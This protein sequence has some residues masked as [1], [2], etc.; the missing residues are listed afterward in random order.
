MTVSHPAGPAHG[1]IRGLPERLAGAGRCLVMGVLN[2]TPDSFSDGGAYLE[3]EV[4]VAHGLR[5]LQKGADII[6][7]GGES[8]RPGA[9]RVSASDEQQRVLPV[10]R[11][12]AGAG[13]VVSIDTMRAETA[14]AA[15]ADGASIIND[16]SGGQAD[17]EMAG[18][19]TEAGVPYVAMHWRGHSDEMYARATYDDVVAEVSTEL[20]ERLGC[21]TSAGVELDQVIL[22]PGFGFAKTAEHN[23]TLLA[24]LGALVGLGRPLLVG[25]SRKRFFDSVLDDVQRTGSAVDRDAATAAVTALAAAAG[26]WAV[27]VH[28]VPA[29]RDAVRVVAR[30]AGVARRG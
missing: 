3:T 30:I 4:A 6:D 29:S 19:V 13:A 18:V 14:G 17:P 8:T 15:V 26:A 20:R 9:A 24:H 21:L 16:V 28:D 7:V 2:V 11:A 5:L 25:A 22:D 10:V 23:W 12:L 27:R 1:A